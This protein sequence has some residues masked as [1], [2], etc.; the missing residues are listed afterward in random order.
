MTEIHKYFAYKQGEYWNVNALLPVS[1]IRKTLTALNWKKEVFASM[2]SY[3]EYGNC[4]YCPLFFDFDGDQITVLKDT[5]A[6][7]NACEFLLNITP[8]VY[9][10]GNRGFHLVIEHMIEHPQCHLLIKDFAEQMVSVSTLDKSIYR[11]N[12]MFRI[13]GSLGSDHNYYKTLLTRTEIMTLNFD[14]IRQLSTTQR[15]IDDQHDPSKID[16]DALSEWLKIAIPELP[17]LTNLTVLESQGDDLLTELTPCIKHMITKPIPTGGRH[18][19]VFIIARFF[20]K[21]GIDHETSL[22]A[23]LRYEHWAEY[24]QKREVSKVFKSV[25]CTTLQT[26]LGCRGP[27][28]SAETMRAYCSDFCHFSPDF[29]EMNINDKKSIWGEHY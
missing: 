28:V 17:D 26:T 9:F 20:K 14:Q 4:L 1:Q 21:C 25:Y 13:P 15:M 7:I 24:E 23:I 2:Q 16:E 18:E 6:F 8:R 10:S 3:D 12:S 29:I 19:A 22:K 5:R 11:T 27:S